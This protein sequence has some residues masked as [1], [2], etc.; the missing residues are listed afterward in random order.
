MTRAFRS[1]RP[2]L[3]V[4]AA[5]FALGVTPVAAYHGDFDVD[6]YDDGVEV[7]TGSNGT[8]AT[9]VPESL[10]ADSLGITSGSCS[11][12]V[13]DDGDGQTDVAD[14]GCINTDGDSVLGVVLD[15]QFE[16]SLAS[17]PNNPGST[18]EHWFLDYVSGGTITSCT[19]GIDDDADGNGVDI[20]DFFCNIDVDLDGSPS[21]Y[22]GGCN[23][24]APSGLFGTPDCTDGE[25]ND[26]DGFV[27]GA[28]SD[29]PDFD[30]DAIANTCDSEGTQ[31]Y[32]AANGVGGS[33]DCFD[34]VD[35]NN[36]GFT[37]YPADPNCGTCFGFTPTIVGTSA[38][39]ALVG[40]PGFD[41]IMALEGDDKIRGADGNDYICAGPGNDKVA[42]G[43]GPDVVSGSDGDDKLVGSSDNDTLLGDGGDDKVIGSSGID[44]LFGGPG[45]DR[46]IG[47]GDGDVLYGDYT[48]IFTV[49]APGDDK[50]VA[51]GGNDY[52]DAG[53]GNDTVLAGGGADAVYGGDGDDALNGGGSGGDYCDGGLGTD[54]ATANCESVGNVP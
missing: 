25:D 50:L 31:G 17:D 34:G 39:E 42:A 14:S 32:G 28:D 20:N 7:F 6:T 22:E 1:I 13:D 4:A 8:S 35:N 15:D 51:G 46:L 41:V 23:L 26:N 10:A 37:D 27:D 12:A 48:Y 16:S 33:D 19:N 2:A 43:P 45:A 9:S 40:T 29:C 38:G 30:G 24:A 44:S 11:N 3:A 36:D 47:S 5:M 52:C 49:I 54:T 21:D 18:P 53:P